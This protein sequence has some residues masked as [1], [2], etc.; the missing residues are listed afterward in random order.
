MRSSAFDEVELVAFGVEPA[1]PAVVVHAV[2]DGLALRDLVK[3]QDGSGRA[4][5]GGGSLASKLIATIE[6]LMKSCPS[7]IGVLGAGA[8]AVDGDVGAGEVGRAGGRQESDDLGDLLRL[9]GPT[10][11]GGLSEGIE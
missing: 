7:S 2:L 10:Q 4:V 6:M 9:A 5:G 1:D 3:H 11:H 8:A